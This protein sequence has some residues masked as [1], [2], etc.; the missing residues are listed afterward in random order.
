MRLSHVLESIDGV[1]VVVVPP[2]RGF[3]ETRGSATLGYAN[4]TGGAVSKPSTFPL[5]FTVV[6]DLAQGFVSPAPPARVIQFF[7]L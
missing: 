5:E 7:M 3:E 2:L 1:S 4:Q 6:F